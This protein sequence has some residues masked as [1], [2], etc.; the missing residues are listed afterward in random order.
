[1][2]H[3]A[4]QKLPGGKLVSVRLECGDK[5]E[6]I[7]IT[8]D[9]FLHPEETLFRIEDALVGMSTSTSEDEIRKKIEDIIRDSK[10]EIIGMTPLAIAQT[11]R[12]AVE[13]QCGE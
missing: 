10:A 7:E 5:I 8:G 6:R 2:M 3:S 4:E 13:S 11:I 12:K 9:F 1:M